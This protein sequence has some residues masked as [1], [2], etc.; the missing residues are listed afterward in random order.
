LGYLNIFL[1]PFLHPSAYHTVFPTAQ[2]QV[3]FDL[4]ES[5]PYSFFIAVCFYSQHF[6]QAVIFGHN[7]H[8]HA[9]NQIHGQL[10]GGGGYKIQPVGG[11]FGR[12]YRHCYNPYPYPPYAGVSQKHFP[13]GKDIGPSDVK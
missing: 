8:F 2:D 13:V 5:Q 11:E 7:F 9:V 1:E 6:L 12:H 3:L 4:P 10:K